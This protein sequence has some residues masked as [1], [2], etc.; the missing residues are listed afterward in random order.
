MAF[1]ALQGP[2]PL[3]LF[4]VK[5]CRFLCRLRSETRVE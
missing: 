4:G 5:M 3:A 2:V 1:R